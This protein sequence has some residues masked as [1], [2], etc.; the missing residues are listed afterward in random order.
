M[1][2]CQKMH[3][4]VL[5]QNYQR[6]LWSKNVTKMKIKVLKNAWDREKRVMSQ[7]EQENVWGKAKALK[8]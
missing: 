2:K 1:W 5:K 3:E 7:L 6:T 4:E 8:H